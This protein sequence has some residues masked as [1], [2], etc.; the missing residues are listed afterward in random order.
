MASTIDALLADPWL[1]PAD[2]LA[3][4]PRRLQLV[5][6]A[7]AF[8]GFGGLFMAPPMV[9]CPDGQLVVLDGDNHWLLFADR[10]G[11]S[12][13]RTEALPAGRRKQGKT[14]FKVEMDG[15]VSCD[16]ERASF[17]VVARSQSSAANA[18]TLAVTTPLSHSVF[19]FAL[20]AG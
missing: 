11:T 13:Q 10:F 5:R 8:R 12:F 16:G 20:A 2:A 3:D 15:R 6:R 4:K 17:P 18:T 1:E 19:L 14:R 9:S 7:G